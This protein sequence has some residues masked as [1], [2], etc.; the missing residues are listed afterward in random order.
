MEVEIC[1][2]EQ[3]WSR[4][5]VC[6]TGLPVCMCVCVCVCVCRHI[7]SCV[8][9]RVCIFVC[10]CACTFALLCV[11]MLVRVRT[12]YVVL[13]RSLV[14]SC[15]TQS[16]VDRC[17]P[18]LLNYNLLYGPTIFKEKLVPLIDSVWDEIISGSATVRLQR[19]WLKWHVC[20]ALGFGNYLSAGATVVAGLGRLKVFA[21]DWYIQLFF[22]QVLELVS[23]FPAAR[24]VSDRWSKGG[25]TLQRLDALNRRPVLLWV[26]RSLFRCL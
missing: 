16:V 6:R 25:V 24:D 7:G 23:A 5:C 10:M 21:V 3:I 26:K 13:K 19:L 20:Y 15:L 9:A 14:V 1:M 17:M 2:F 8:L 12:S 18:V 11:Y 4:A 22:L